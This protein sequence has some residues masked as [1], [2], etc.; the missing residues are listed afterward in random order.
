MCRS[1]GCSG[2]VNNAAL[3][4]NTFL[5]SYDIAV[6]IPPPYIAVDMLVDNYIHAIDE[7]APIY[8]NQYAPPEDVGMAGLMHSELATIL[9][10]E[11]SEAVE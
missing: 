7:P 5:P 9:E 2:L 4:W 11:L 6:S 8:S 10:E 3:T 1:F